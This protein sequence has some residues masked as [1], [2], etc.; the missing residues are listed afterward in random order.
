M[1]WHWPAL[2]KVEAVIITS[3]FGDQPRRALARHGQCPEVRYPICYGRTLQTMKSFNALLSLVSGLALFS[4][5]ASHAIAIAEST[6]TDGPHT[7]VVVAADTIRP[8]F[9]CFRIGVLKNLKFNRS[10]V[11]WHLYSF[12]SRTAADAARSSSGIVV[13][14][15]GRVWLSEFGARNI[16]VRGGSRAAV[17]GPLKLVPANSY[18]AEIAYSVMN[19]SHHSRVH[20]HSGPEA[21]YV[22]TGVQCL[23]TPDVTRRAGPG[24]TM[25]A[26]ANRPMELRVAESDV[27]RSLTLV[28]HGSTQEF[29]AASDW[30]PTVA[31]R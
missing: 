29:G 21:W 11:Y 4:L 6:G 28:I 7:C 31:C 5:P 9:G 22:L 24:A 25:T 17:I 10:T 2:T 23:E 15:D 8:E 12:P 19:S 30:K 27:A 26:A 3:A 14:E 16:R 18:D 1:G 20:T 13:E